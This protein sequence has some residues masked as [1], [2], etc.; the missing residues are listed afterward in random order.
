MNERFWRKAIIENKTHIK[1]KQ[2]ES[3]VKKKKIS[4]QYTSETN[5]KPVK[6]NDSNEKE[7][8]ALMP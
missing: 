7:D 5:K 8:I 1:R 6:H 2:L 4:N 3:I